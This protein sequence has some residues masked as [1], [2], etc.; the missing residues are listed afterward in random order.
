MKACIYT[1]Y[2]T[3]AIHFCL[4]LFIYN[5]LAI[6][7]R[8]REHIYGLYIRHERGFCCPDEELALLRGENRRNMLLSV[9]LL[10]A[11]AL[12]YSAF[13]YNDKSSW[14]S[15]VVGFAGEPF[16]DHGDVSS[17]RST[18]WELEMKYRRPASRWPCRFFPDF[19]GCRTGLFQAFLDLKCL[20]FLAESTFLSSCIIYSFIH[21]SSLAA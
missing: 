21:S 5:L 20:P 19:S 12:F 7:A 10:A 1:L 13:L 4:C 18:K 8:V 17:I 11:S 9:A 15:Y 16:R 6:T 2:H 14:W 3:V